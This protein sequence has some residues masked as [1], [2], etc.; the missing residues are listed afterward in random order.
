VVGPVSTSHHLPLGAL[1][2]DALSVSR[3]LL[4]LRQL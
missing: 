1:S 3:G 2:L 4:Y